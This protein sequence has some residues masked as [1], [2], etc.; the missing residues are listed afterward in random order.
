MRILFDHNLPRPLRRVLLGH[1]VELSGELGWAEL[2]NGVLL[3]SAETG[4]FDVMI[5]ADQNIAYQQNLKE[6]KIALV[7]LGSN[8]WRYV[9]AHLTEIVAAVND[10]RTG[11][12][13]FI[14]VPLPPKPKYQ[15]TD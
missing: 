1:L 12:Y 14:E 9:R 8:R 11:S 7:V 6:R 5:T 15:R 10:A 2:K 4:G 3:K 13:A